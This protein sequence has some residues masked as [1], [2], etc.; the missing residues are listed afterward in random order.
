LFFITSTQ[1]CI[2]FRNLPWAKLFIPFWGSRLIPDLNLSLLFAGDKN[3][4]KISNLIY[5]IIKILREESNGT[6]D[7]SLAS[8]I[9]LTQSYSVKSQEKRYLFL[10]K[11]FH[12]N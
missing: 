6:Y 11:K 2:P 3:L 7:Y 8:E 9:V 4:N 10:F 12:F 5:P 1:G